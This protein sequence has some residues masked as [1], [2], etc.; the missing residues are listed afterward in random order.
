MYSGTECTLSKSADNIKL[1]GAVDTLERQDATQ[2]DLGRL[3]RWA[4]A[5][6]MKFNMA[7]GKVLYVGRGNPKHKYRLGREQIKSS[8]EEK[9]LGVLVHEKLNISH[10][11]ALAA[12]KANCILGCIK[13]SVTSRAREGILPL[14]SALV[15]LHLE[16]CVQLWS[17]QHRK[18]RELVEWV[19]RRLQK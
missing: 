8:P 18:D 15:R 5:T 3:E 12:Q 13:R 9:D 4:P 17:P 2:R 14:C 1:S 16:S 10:Q 7:K 19:Q 6:F 11:S